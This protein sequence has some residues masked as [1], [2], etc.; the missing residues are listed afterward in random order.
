[1]FVAGKAPDGRRGRASAAVPPSCFREAVGATRS[2]RRGGPGARLPV[3]GRLEEEGGGGRAG[4]ERGA[5]VGPSAGI[6]RLARRA[7]QARGPG[8]GALTLEQPELEEEEEERRRERRRRGRVAPARRAWGA[9][10]RGLCC[11]RSCRWVSARGA[12]RGAGGSARRG[13]TGGARL[14]R[15]AWGADGA[16]AT[17]GRAGRDPRAAGPGGERAR[18]ARGASR[19]APGRASPAHVRGGSGP[20]PASPGPPYLLASRGRLTL[21]SRPGRCLRSRP[22]SPARERKSAA[23]ICP[24]MAET[25]RTAL[26]TQS[27]A[28]GCLSREA[29]G[30]ANF[31]LRR[32]P[33]GPERYSKNRCA[34]PSVMLVV[35]SSSAS[36]FSFSS[37]EAASLHICTQRPGNLGFFNFSYLLLFLPCCPLFST[38]SQPWCLFIIWPSA[39]PQPKESLV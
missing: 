39:L 1:M 2:A 26:H 14:P 7:E 30:S 20:R 16:G 3:P 15:A 38:L 19:R 5:H 35:A 27:P 4:A 10:R 36:V 13:G 21:N 24:A 25:G 12:R 11:W 28:P 8:G 18:I 9:W 22:A 6:S 17:P 34:G 23:L 33:G 37:S 29:R 32:S 31:L